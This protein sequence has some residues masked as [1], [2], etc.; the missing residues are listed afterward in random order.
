MDLEACEQEI[1]KIFKLVFPSLSNERL[2]IFNR[3]IE[4]E[5]DSLKQIELITEI[6]ELFLIELS[7][8][9]VDFIKDLSSATSTV[10]KLI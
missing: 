2:I 6:E 10:F 4:P 7:M 3:D 9:D 1:K 5:W 8:E